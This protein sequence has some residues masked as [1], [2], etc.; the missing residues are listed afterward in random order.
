MQ[1][2]EWALKAII[3]R[4]VKC[5]RTLTHNQWH[6]Q[7]LTTTLSIHCVERFYPVLSISA[8]FHRTT[9]DGHE[10]IRYRSQ[11]VQE[12]LFAST[13]VHPTE[14]VLSSVPITRKSSTESHRYTGT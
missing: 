7:P 3:M 1:H 2:T 9:E 12:V 6:G 10:K 13:S 4:P 8:R 14:I 5:R 11:L